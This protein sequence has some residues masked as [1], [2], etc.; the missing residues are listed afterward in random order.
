MSFYEQFNEIKEEMKTLYL[1]SNIPFVLAVSFGK[2]SSLMLSLLW[3]ALLSIPKEQRTKT[4]YVI[5]S[6]TL[7]ELDAVSAYLK[8]SLQMVQN[9]AKELDLPIET[10]LVRP[11]MKERYFWNVLAKGNPPVVPKSKRFRWCTAKLKQSPIDR[12][13]REIQH[14]SPIN[15]DSNHDLYLF[16]G[17]R[18][19]ESI[20]RKN[21]IQK[22]AIDGSKFGRHSKYDRVCAYYPIKYIHGSAVWGYLYDCE[23]LP[24]GMPLSTLES[25]YP[26][27]MYECG[28]KTD[29][30]QSSCGGGR[31]GCWTCTFVNEDKMLDEEVKKGNIAAKYLY[32]YKKLLA[33]I[34]NDARYRQATRRNEH[35]KLNKRVEQRKDAELNLSLFDTFEASLEEEQSLHDY[36]SFQRGSDLDYTAGSLTFEARK[37]LLEHLLYTEQITGLTLIEQ[38]EV[39]AILELWR[40]E[41][42]KYGLIQPRK[43]VYDGAVVFDQ[44]FKP[45]EKE[46]QNPQPQ[47]WITREFD[48]NRDEVIEYIRKREQETGKSFYY[49]INHWDFGEEEE[50]VYN[51]AVFLICQENVNSE[52]EAG[53]IIDE[54]LY[55]KPKEEY[56]DW[57]RFAQRYYARAADLLSQPFSNGEEL[58]RINKVLNTLG[59]PPVKDKYQE[60]NVF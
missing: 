54:W 34:R 20:Q 10:V 11:E 17:T 57:D 51:I 60:R 35:K 6:D 56:I 3:E 37:L 36:Y 38:E 28:L 2:D 18:D 41:G 24:W 13:I 48:C 53:K 50:F 4:V 33:A 15:I 45:N 1:E 43:F 58:N 39:Q 19:S 29:G 44:N 40:D 26:E 55:P 16:L 14:R 47:F 5:S 25:F 49:N 9:K 52:M 59:Y 31:N 8:T 30:Q 7:V 46:T 23:T 32:D 22:F 42:Y 27:G 12:V 21:S